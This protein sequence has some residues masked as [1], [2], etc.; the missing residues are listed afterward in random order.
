M[1]LPEMLA[2]LADVPGQLA[3]HIDNLYLAGDYMGIPSV[4]GAL[5]TGESTANQVA[6]LSMSGA[7]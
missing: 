7:G 1:G 2:A 5:S 6:D 3:G 4:N